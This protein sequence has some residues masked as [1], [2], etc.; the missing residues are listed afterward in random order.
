MQQVNLGIIGGGTV[1]SG[2][3]EALQRN[4]P[5]SRLPRRRRRSKSTPRLVRDSKE[6]TRHCDSRKGM[7]TTDWREVVFDPQVQLVA[8]LIGGTTTAKE[9]ILAAHA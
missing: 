6:E 8:E 9:I 7:L 1:G 4:G 5:T 2:V 3:Y